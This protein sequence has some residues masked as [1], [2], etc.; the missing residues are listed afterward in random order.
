MWIVEDIPDVDDEIP[1]RLL[2]PLNGQAGTN[3][4]EQRRLIRG[5]LYF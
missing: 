4:L 2:S 1:A 5:N 3:N